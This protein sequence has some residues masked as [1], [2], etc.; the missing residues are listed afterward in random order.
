VSRL[1]RRDNNTSMCQNADPSGRRGSVAVVVR[2]R[3]LLVVR[4]SRLVVAPGALCFPGGAI[5]R[6]ESEEEALK[7]EMLEEL[8]VKIRPERR[9]WQSVTPWRVH[10]S[11]WLGHLEPDAEL[12]PNP[13]EIE[14]VHWLGPDEMARHPHLLESNRHFL[15]ALASGEI[16]LIV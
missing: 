12:V 15:E 3:R 8:G 10:L 4:R 14:S 11:W 7:R 16:D 1:R 9:I 2:R 6:G 5:E 13:A